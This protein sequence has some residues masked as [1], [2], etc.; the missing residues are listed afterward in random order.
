[1]M[2]HLSGNKEAM[3]VKNP[4]RSEILRSLMLVSS[5]IPE[6]Y[7]IGRLRYELYEVSSL[8]ANDE[9]DEFALEFP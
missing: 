2:F 4:H 3:A 8:L 1:M 9:D 7:N 6:L 5:S